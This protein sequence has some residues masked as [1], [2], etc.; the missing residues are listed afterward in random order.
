MNRTLT[1]LAVL[2]ASV[3]YSALAIAA[4][5]AGEVLDANKAATGGSAWDSKTALKLQ[6]AYSGQ[7]MTGTVTSLADL[8]GGRWRDD[9]AIGPATLANGYDGQHA[10]AKD[11]SGTITIQDGGEQRALAVN[12]GYRRANLWWQPDRNGAKV[13]SDGEKTDGGATYDVLTVTPRDGKNFDAWFDAKTHLLSRVIEQQG[14]QTI[15]STTSDYRAV[16]GV[17]LAYDDHITN[18]E[19]KYDQ[20][21]KL[22]TATFLPMQPDSAFAAPKNNVNDF[23]IAGNATETTFPFHL[24][25]NHIYADVTVN[26][27][28][29]YQFIFDTGGVNL[30]TPPLA[31]ALGLKAEGQMEVNGA[32]S[33]HMDTGM[34]KVSSLQL[35]NATI[36]SQL[37]MV[38]PLDSMSYIEGVGMPGMV[39]FETFRRFVTRVDYGNGTITLIKPDAFDPKDAGVAV[40]FVF[41]GNS[42][43]A[44]ATYNGVTAKFTIDTGSRASLTLNGPF[45]AKNGLDTSGKTIDSVTGW[46]VGGPSRGITLRG[47][48]LTIGAF[49]IEGPV[50][51]VSTDKGGAFADASIGGNIG[52]GIL[53]RYIV[54]LDYNRSTM[55]L[56]PVTTP[57]ADLDT[58][59]RSGM[60][61]NESGKDGF[62]VVDVTKDAAADH[63]GLK[64]GDIIVAVDGKPASSIHLYDLRQRLRDDAPGTVVNFAVKRGTQNLNVPVS[65]ADQ[66]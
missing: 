39:G 36:N 30:V 23:S 48:P 43:E 28:G 7:G 47:K 10:W 1:A 27:K 17:E 63:A 51:E 4:P 13:V 50:V 24:Y 8:K 14:P 52:A 26:G 25:N 59:D 29:P 11:Q 45:A 20:E 2:A 60:W 42:I 19:V 62:A 35:G 44:P 3:S 56:K 5:S 57:V 61:I 40:P 46:G 37:F 34:T 33:G 64:V 31:T 12:D 55:Y 22:V 9:I 18:G 21:V 53:K 32:G 54:T 38:M 65:L 49:T 15:T 6:Y 66:I 41:D 16:D 58:F